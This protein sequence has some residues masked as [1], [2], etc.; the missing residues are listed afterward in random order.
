MVEDLCRQDLRRD[1]RDVPGF[2]I[3]LGRLFFAT[4]EVAAKTIVGVLASPEAATSA[5][6]ASRRSLRPC[7][8]TA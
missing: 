1:G 4:P 8:T 6:T 2:F 5:R 3:A 7:R